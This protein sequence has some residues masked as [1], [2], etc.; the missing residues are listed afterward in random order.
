REMNESV[1]YEFTAAIIQ[2]YATQAELL[3]ETII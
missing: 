3:G 2:D 1:E